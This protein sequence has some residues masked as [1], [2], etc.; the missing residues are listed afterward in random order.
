MWRS[1]EPAAVGVALTSSFI[2]DGESTS[3]LPASL[4]KLVQVSVA[5]LAV[6][7]A[8]AVA[9]GVVVVVDSVCFFLQARRAARRSA[10]R[11][12]WVFMRP[13][14]LHGSPDRASVV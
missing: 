3:N 7:V 1:I 10:M 5:A 6:A 9:T 4:L 8:V 13:T 2:D 14:S 12:A 11:T